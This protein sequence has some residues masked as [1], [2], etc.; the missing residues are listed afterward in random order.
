[1]KRI[2]DLLD[3]IS[4]AELDIPIEY[5]RLTNDAMGEIYNG[6]GPD[7]MSEISRSIL[8]WLLRYFAAAFLIHDLE[9]HFNTDP[10]HS[11]ENR[12][13][14]RTANK[15]MWKNI[16]KLNANNFSWYNPRRWYWRAKG[17]LAYKACTRHGWSAWIAVGSQN[18][19]TISNLKHIIE[20]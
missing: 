5:L 2:K 12:K 8:S 6:A 3:Q 17:Y 15:R 14:F 9:F 19:H 11:K 4:E 13:R 7:W 20:D 1:M 18:N 10:F 16:K